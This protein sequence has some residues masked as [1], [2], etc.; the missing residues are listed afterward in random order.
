MFMY[1]DLPDNLWHAMLNSRAVG[2]PTCEGPSCCECTLANKPESIRTIGMPTY[3]VDLSAYRQRSNAPGSVAMGRPDSRNGLQQGRADNLAAVANM[4][5]TPMYVSDR[6][7]PPEDE[8]IR[9]IEV[10]GCE[11]WL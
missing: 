11:R 5:K 7:M 9:S 3:R 4:L 8:T 2:N 1:H 6:A 10:C